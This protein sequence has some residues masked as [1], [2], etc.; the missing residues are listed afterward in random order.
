M[1]EGIEITPALNTL[2]CHRPNVLHGTTVHDVV[3]PNTPLDVIHRGFSMFLAIGM[4]QSWMRFKAKQ[5]GMVQRGEDG[6]WRYDEDYEKTLDE[7]SLS[8]YRT[9]LKLRENCKWF[10]MHKV[11]VA[12][13]ILSCE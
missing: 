8:N 11:I 10:P 4:Q 2:I 13:Q 12:D 6:V 7:E 3:R 5:N 9:N 1:K